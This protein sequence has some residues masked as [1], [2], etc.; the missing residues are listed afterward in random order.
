MDL[1]YVISDSVVEN[2]VDHLKRSQSILFI[3]GAGVSAESG[4]P[5][6][7]GVGGLYSNGLTAEGVTIEEALSAR[8]LAQNPEVTWKY[9]R[10]IGE[11]VSNRKHNVVHEIVAEFETLFPR[12]W[13][14]TQNIDGYHRTAGARNLIEIHGCMDTLFCTH[15]DFRANRFAPEIQDELA[16]IAEQNDVPTCPKCQRLVRPDVTLFGEGL[17]ERGIAKLQEELAVGFDVVI[18]IGTSSLFHYIQAPVRL[19]KRAG[20]FAVEINPDHTDIS[21]I[22]DEHIRAGAGPALKAIRDKYLESLS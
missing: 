19:A 11:A 4:I 18:S 13:T 3:T 15:C 10:Q 14:L 8:M 9:L 16:R 6:Y 2:I 5:T 22:V 1:E 7:R 20:K 17:P 12:V 21:D